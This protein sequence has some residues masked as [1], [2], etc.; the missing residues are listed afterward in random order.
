MSGAEVVP[1]YVDFCNDD[2]ASDDICTMW[3]VTSARDSPYQ[4]NTMYLIISISIAMS[5]LIKTY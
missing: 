4:Y 5:P 2:G 3:A 1:A